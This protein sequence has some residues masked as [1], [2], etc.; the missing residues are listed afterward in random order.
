MPYC[1]PM[2]ENEKQKL[3]IVRVGSDKPEKVKPEI[4]RSWIHEPIKQD[5]EIVRKGSDEPVKSTRSRLDAANKKAPWF[6]REALVLTVTPAGMPLGQGS[7]VKTRRSFE[8]AVLPGA[9]VEPHQAP[10]RASRGP[11]STFQSHQR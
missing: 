1:F 5:I 8:P 2:P 10:V 9:A 3:N 11:R 6:P 4:V 7:P